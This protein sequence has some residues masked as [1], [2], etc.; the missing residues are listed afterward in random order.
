MARWLLSRP[1]NFAPVTEQRVAEALSR[2]PETWLIRWGFLYS[3]QGEGIGEFEGDFII[4][5]PGGHGL[6]LEVKGTATRNFVLTGHWEGEPGGENPWLQLNSQWNWAIRRARAVAAGRPLPF[7][8]RAL[9]LPQT[10]LVQGD[11]FRGGIP[12]AHVVDVSDL[13][14]FEGWW[15]KNVSWHPLHGSVTDARGVF[16]DAFAAGIKP[17][18]VRFFIRQ[19]EAFFEQ[20]A[21]H[22]SRLLRMLDENRQLLI[23][24]GAGSGK[25]SLAVGQARHYAGLG[26][27]TLVLCYNLALADHLRA[28]LAA[29][30]DLYGG[31]EVRSWEEL[32][33]V[34]LAEAGIPFEPPS[35][36]QVQNEYYTVTVPFLL[37]ELVC[38]G[39]IAASY[40]A[41][42]VDEAQ[43]HDTQFDDRLNARD[44]LGWW[45]IYFAL[46]KKGRQAPIALF[47]DPEQRPAF[48]QRDRFD[49][50]RLRGGLAESAHLRLPAA[51]RFTRPIRTF[52]EGLSETGAAGMVHQLGPAGDYL[53]EG[54]EVE[55]AQTGD[56][57]EKTIAEIV[58]RW[59]RTGLCRRKDIVVVGPRSRRADSGLGDTEDVD[60]IPLRD[61]RIG[62]V[63]DA[64]QY[65]SINKSKGLDFLG[66]IVIDLP[67]PED[68]PA[69]QEN[70]ELLFMAASRARQL[71]AVIWT[72]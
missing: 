16:S 23:Q 43:D 70:H 13:R 56:N 37:W 59:E 44:A 4:Q 47:F 12:R 18:E 55:L 71:L 7:I 11:L 22:D 67:Q 28:L 33:R 27:R 36:R 14:N 57:L 31:I 15:E 24:G 49:P 64:L 51:L 45:E 48:R 19:T 1:S 42:V 53:P 66:I 68:C 39:K 35:D 8:Y 62:P 34:I 2:L 25:T 52:L 32:V 5:G 38:D 61:Y 41:L 21:Q 17:K 26:L 6:V 30:R 60:G 10:Q 58:I 3:R 29:D 72:R 50:K 20:Q 46:L 65:L 54:P 63:A 69:K 40:D 9:A